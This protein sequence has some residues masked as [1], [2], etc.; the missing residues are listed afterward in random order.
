MTDRGSRPSSAPADPAHGAEL[1]TCW[2]ESARPEWRACARSGRQS[3]HPESLEEGTSMSTTDSTIIMNPQPP[4]PPKRHRVRNTVLIISGVG[5]AAV[6]G[7]SAA[8][9]GSSSTPATSA[10]AAAPSTSAPA[11]PAAP[12]PAAPTPTVAQPTVAQPTVAQQQALESAQSYLDMG[13]GFSRAGLIDQ[14]HS[15]AGE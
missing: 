7:A 5:L 1:R 10:P 4:K 15:S 14:L 11:A 2:P 3:R 8:G 9:A 12:A 6:I 13:T